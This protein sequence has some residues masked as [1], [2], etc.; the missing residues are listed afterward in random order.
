MKC[1]VIMP[2]SETQHKHGHTTKVTSAIEWGYIYGNFIKKAVESYNGGKFTCKRSETVPGNFVKGII[3]D[4]HDSDLI[5]ADLTGQKPNVYYELGIRHALRLGTILLTQDFGAVPSDLRS[6]YCFEYVYSNKAHTYNQEFEEFEKSLHKHIDFVLANSNASDNPVSDFLQLEH[7]YH[8]ENLRREKA[9]IIKILDR[10][11]VQLH[12]IFA[13]FQAE[14]AGREECIKNNEIFFTFL[15]FGH[16]D[17][18]VT[19]LF[20]GTFR[21]IKEEQLERAL[22]FYVALRRDLYHV[23]QYWE[24]TRQHIRD[25]N[26]IWLMNLMAGVLKKQESTLAELDLIKK[27]INSLK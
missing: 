3:Q 7:Y 10:L 26:I 20:N 5:I 14:I 13:K 4:L 19:R 11:L 15:D 17:G 12:F 25:T 23:Y 16:L 21:A 18:I 2:F 22:N 1:F 24:G 27:E 8:I 6:Y 9:I